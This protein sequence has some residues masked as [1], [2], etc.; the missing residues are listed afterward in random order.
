[1]V[2]LD[3]TYTNGVIAA[4]EKRLLKEKILRFCE[5][6]AEEAF[7]AL[8]DSGFGGGA[9]TATSVFEYEKL[10]GAEEKNVDEF[11]RVYAPS[12]AE[13]AYLLAPRDFH[14]AKALVKAAFLNTAPERMLSPE[15]LVSIE[16]I[17]ECISQ[18]DFS[19]LKAL[20]A[21]MGTACEESMAFLSEQ[22]SGAKVGEIFEKALYSYLWEI[23]K[24]KRVLRK[25]LTAKIDMT[26]I[27]I[28][29]R[30]ENELQAKKQYLCEGALS[31]KKLSALF[32]DDYERAKR[33]FA[34][35]DYVD[36]VEKCFEAKEKSL[37]YSEAEKMRDGFDVCFFAARKY[38]L[39]KSEPFLYYVYRC[40]VEN[41]N[42]RVVFVCLLAG[43]NE[44][45]I[46][47]RLRAV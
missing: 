42:V 2:Y 29:F 22:S 35:T 17:K 46:K 5:L 19:R 3:T 41:A 26:N 9:E 30:A 44:H 16:L 31:F 36:F 43:M 40:R 20:N 33:A 39:Q 6:D 15:G 12:E 24:G 21:Y 23:S 25:L 4:R 11:I 13:R 27:L 28:A 18:A 38:D 45:E 47:K 14:N 32:D 8:L 1:M 34:T 7:R 37:P 10:V